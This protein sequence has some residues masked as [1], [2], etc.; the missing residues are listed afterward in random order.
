[1]FVPVCRLDIYLAE[2]AVLLYPFIIVERPRFSFEAKSVGS[3]K[4]GRVRVSD[5]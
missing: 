1:V 3:A 4:L 2:M 5:T